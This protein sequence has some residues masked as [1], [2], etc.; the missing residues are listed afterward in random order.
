[1]NYLAPLES[2]SNILVTGHGARSITGVECGLKMNQITEKQLAAIPGIGAKSAW[3]LV[4]ERAKA[5]SKGRD[6]ENLDDWFNSI[7]TQLPELA[8]QIIDNP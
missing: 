3:N 8:E 5:I 7:D 2:T 6:F 1:M 4:S